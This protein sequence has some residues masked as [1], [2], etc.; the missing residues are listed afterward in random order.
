MVASTANLGSLRKLQEQPRA[1][2]KDFEITSQKLFSCV[3]MET[4][5]SLEGRSAGMSDRHTTAILTAINISPS[6]ISSPKI[7]LSSASLASPT[8]C[9]CRSHC[10][11]L[12]PL[13]A[14]PKNGSNGSLPVNRTPK[15][16]PKLKT[17]LLSVYLGH[18]K[19]FN[20][21]NL[22]ISKYEEQLH[23]LISFLLFW[24]YILYS[25]KMGT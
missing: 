3:S 2:W 12:P 14:S 25:N 1:L 11:R 10:P 4:S 18:N 19:I 8:C 7:L 6:S 20:G 23:R 17:S 22:N 13:P 9:K 21:Q 15:I 16:T 24:N 5:S